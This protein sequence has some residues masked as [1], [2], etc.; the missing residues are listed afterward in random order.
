MSEIE[1]RTY[2]IT[3]EPKIST[4]D[5]IMNERQRNPFEVPFIISSKTCKLVYFNKTHKNYYE[6]KVDVLENGV[7]DVYFKSV[8]D[9]EANVGS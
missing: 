5:A 1:T 9:T 7:P 3:A 6:F 4:Y 2:T 8:T